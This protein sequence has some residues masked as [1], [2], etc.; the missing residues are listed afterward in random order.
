MSFSVVIF[1]VSFRLTLGANG[2]YNN[3]KGK[4]MNYGDDDTNRNDDRYKNQQNDTD[5]SSGRG[6]YGQGDDWAAI[7]ANIADD[8]LFHWDNNVGFDGVSIMPVSCIN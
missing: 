4:Y 8:D 2:Y 7:N 1:M 3:Y 6:S 5:D